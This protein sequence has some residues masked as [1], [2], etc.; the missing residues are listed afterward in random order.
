MRKRR[1]YFVTLDLGRGVRA[2]IQLGLREFR[3][4]FKMN[5]SRPIEQNGALCRS[6]PL[7]IKKAGSQKLPR[8]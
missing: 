4:L 5:G 2:C 8:L 7:S 3:P 1:F 6:F